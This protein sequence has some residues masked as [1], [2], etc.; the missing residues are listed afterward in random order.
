MK[1]A[2]KA[3]AG[4]YFTDE[5]IIY[6]TF[7]FIFLPYYL[8]ALWLI[9]SCIYI[10]TAKKSSV[11]LK[12]GT[13]IFAIV[14]FVYTVIT[15]MLAKNLI[16]IACSFGFIA[17]IIISFYARERFTPDIFEK[18]LNLCCISGAVTGAF[19]I[20]EY[21]YNTSVLHH[22]GVYRCQLYFFNSN[23][24]ATVLATVIIIC[25]YK[26]ITY[27]KNR[28]FYYS[29]ALLC[30]IGTYLTG[31]MFVWVEVLIGISVLLLLTRCHQLLSILLLLAVTACIVLYCAPQI[32][33]RIHDS[34]IT[35]DNR[36][37]IWKVS[38]EAIK[39]SPVFGKGF[40]TYFHIYKHYPHSYPTT[41]AHNIFIEPILSFGIIGT[42]LLV[43]FFTGYY[44][45]VILC[46]NAQSKYY[47]TALILSIT[48][49][50]LIHGTTDLTFMW[51]QTGFLYCMISGSVGIEE[52]FLK[53]ET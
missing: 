29:C 15:A 17:M 38:I 47:A 10:I 6:A 24:L 18:S 32:V 42:I 13:N 39:R 16:G 27:R 51:I 48:A 53:L 14:F 9:F 28:I 35:T 34:N 30:T 26:V 43:V 36:V 46:R 11:K 44:K 41:H 21:L 22:R 1:S 45:R 12:S 37:L 3:F 7:I 23:Y 19:A 50:L 4:K 2:I 33:P 49:A 31:S 52:R 20:I 8:T 25:A 40:L 5:N